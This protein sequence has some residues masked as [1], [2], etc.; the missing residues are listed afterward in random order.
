[1]LGR[2]IAVGIR[3]GKLALGRFQSIVFAEL[4]GE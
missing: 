4:D 3:Q 1:L 2:S